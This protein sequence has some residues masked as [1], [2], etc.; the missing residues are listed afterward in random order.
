MPEIKVKNSSKEISI[1]DSKD[2]SEFRRIS[3]LIGEN[4]IYDFRLQAA[5]D[6]SRAIDEPATQQTKTDLSIFDNLHYRLSFQSERGHFEIDSKAVRC[7]LSQVPLNLV[8]EDGRLLATTDSKILE[9]SLAGQIDELFKID[10]SFTADTED[11]ENSSGRVGYQLEKLRTDCFL[12]QENQKITF[13]ILD[14]EKQFTGR[15]ICEKKDGQDPVFSMQIQKDR[16]SIFLQISPEKNIFLAE[17][18]FDLT[19][20]THFSAGGVISESQ[21]SQA[22]GISYSSQEVGKINFD[23]KFNQDSE[24]GSGFEAYLNLDL[25][26]LLKK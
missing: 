22:F 7:D 17:A 21:L 24:T 9:N 12:S 1:S 23:L 2:I 5:S 10:W 26:N 14:P 13:S 19:D 11:L 8:F 6:L 15:L 16:K 25:S 4:L 3:D 18:G 20:R